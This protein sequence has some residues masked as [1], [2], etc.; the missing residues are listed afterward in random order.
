[1]R[2]QLIGNYIP[3]GQESMQRYVSSLSSAL[4]EAGFDISV[5][6]PPVLFGKLR[7][8]GTGTKLFRYLDKFLVFSIV[9]L[10]KSGE[11]DVI[12]ICDHGNA[13]YTWLFFGRCTIVTCH[14]LF[15]IG[16]ASGH[17]P[18]QP[19]SRLG[20][21]LQAAIVA[22]IRRASGIV[23]V[24]RNTASSL[25]KLVFGGSN[26][27]QVIHH[28]LNWSYCPASPA[29]VRETRERLNLPNKYLLHVGGNHWYKNRDGLLRIISQLK[30]F[31]DFNQVNLVM[32]GKPLTTALKLAIKNLGIED[33][34]IAVNRIGNEDLASLYTGATALLFPSL[35]E[36]FGWPILEAQ[37]CGC[38]VI[39]SD[40]E[41]MR[42]VAGA[43]ALFID[44]TD[45]LGA[46][47]CIARSAKCFPDLRAAGFANLERFNKEKVLNEYVS[48]YQSVLA[49]VQD[50]EPERS[51]IENGQG[52]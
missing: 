30:R 23:C 26:H 42:E 37:A 11:S 49:S 27:S 40:R 4:Q 14:D 28:S 10:L 39:T 48:F 36:G 16:A 17:C 19:I 43:G 35:A 24:S 44:P 33:S 38:P 18:E 31:P 32:V 9:L 52:R 47:Q 50:R 29:E 15:A 51:F 6:R 22:G 7:Q 13:M 34:V 5:A 41:P 20:H 1:M 8:S 12:H 45:P 3:D 2:I 46:A 21:I 25:D